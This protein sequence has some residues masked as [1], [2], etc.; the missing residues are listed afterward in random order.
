MD[1]QMDTAFPENCLAVSLN[2][3]NIRSSDLFS[4][5]KLNDLY[6]KINGSISIPGLFILM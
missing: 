2:I 1:V 6:T 3:L 4:F 5:W